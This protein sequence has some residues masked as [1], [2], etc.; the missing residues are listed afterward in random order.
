MISEALCQLETQFKPRDLGTQE[1]TVYIP[2]SLKKSGAPAQ[3]EEE[4]MSPPFLCFFPFGVSVERMVPTH[5]EE[6]NA[7]Y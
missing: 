2:V 1:R 6:G 3:A 5:I 4:E 7:L